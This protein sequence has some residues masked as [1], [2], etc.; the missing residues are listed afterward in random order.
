MSA[1]EEAGGQGPLVPEACILGTR[2][3][4][5]TCCGTRTVSKSHISSP[6]LCVSPLIHFS[7]RTL[8]Q[9]LERAGSR[10][11]TS[12]PHGPC[13]PQHPQLLGRSITREVW[14]TTP[15]SGAI[16]SVSACGPRFS[17]GLQGLRAEGL[18]GPEGAG[19]LLAGRPP[20]P[21]NGQW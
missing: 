5:L 8:G 17:A 9:A 4:S 13:H 15:T 2:N 19:M 21:S 7:A 20:R 6:S 10:M 1:R 16:R 18:K 12:W 14:R 11:E 3:S